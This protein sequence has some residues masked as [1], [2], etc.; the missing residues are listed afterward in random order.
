MRGRIYKNSENF[1][2][3]NGGGASGGASTAEIAAAAG[4]VAGQIID[5]I[6]KISDAK[7]RR[8]FE[9]RL[10]L[11]NTSQQNELNEK[12]L[13]ASTQNE[14]R[15]ILAESLSATAIARIQ[16]ANKEK[17]NILLYVVGGIIIL[18]AA[19]IVYRKFT[20]K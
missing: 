6:S 11:L 20:K 5:S 18:G 15:R 16:A 7:K 19:F 14:K 2:G 10:A 12:L 17:M 1:I 13:Q 3:A 4:E 9:E 8:Q